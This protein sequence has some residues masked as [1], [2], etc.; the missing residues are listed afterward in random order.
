[1]KASYVL[2]STAALLIWT[3][4][5]CAQAKLGTPLSPDFPRESRYVSYP[6]G[7]PGADAGFEYKPRHPLLSNLARKVLSPIRAATGHLMPPPP[8]VEVPTKDGVA[9]MIAA[10][11]Y[12]PAEIS[13]AK[14]KIDEAQGNTRRAAVRYLGTVD[15]HYYPEAELG[16]IA[17]L[18]ADRI[19]SVRFEAALAI[20]NCR[21]ATSRMLE[22]LHLA[23][24]GSDWDGN[25]AETSERVRAVARDVLGRGTGAPIAEW[26]PV[27][28]PMVQ[29]MMEPIMQPIMEFPPWLI[30]D[31]SLV[32]PT[33]YFMPAPLPVYQPTMPVAMPPVLRQDR[34]RAQTVSVNLPNASA[35]PA[36]HPFGQ[37]LLGLLP[38][39]ESRSAG[40]STAKGVDPRLRGLSPLGSEVNL[41]MPYPPNSQSL[42][43]YNRP[44]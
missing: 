7:V 8:A 44:E 2:A 17:A 18:R 30:P 6:T 23:A 15:C 19:E 41:A 38:F 40:I 10:G 39:R 31:P 4:T 22:A 26:Q 43:P 27:I 25:P 42:R 35:A 24:S 3:G 33:S 28:E 29:L 1:M 11:D 32:E 12:S 14:I 16:L 13:A 9:R 37:L 21:G 5:V 34:E 36:S 20:G